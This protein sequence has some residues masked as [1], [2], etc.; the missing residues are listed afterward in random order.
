MPVD[1]PPNKKPPLSAEATFS[2]LLD[3]SLNWLAV[4]VVIALLLWAYELGLM[5]LI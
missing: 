1:L 5:P 4:V 3:R 2:L